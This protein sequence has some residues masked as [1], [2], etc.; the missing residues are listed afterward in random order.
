MVVTP[1]TCPHFIPHHYPSL[2]CCG[3]HLNI[4]QILAIPQIYDIPLV[5]KWNMHFACSWIYIFFLPRGERL[6]WTEEGKKSLEYDEC[7]L[8]TGVWVV[9]FCQHC[10]YSRQQSYR[11]I[12]HTIITVI[13]CRSSYN[14]SQ[15]ST[16][17]PWQHKHVLTQ[18]ALHFNVLH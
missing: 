13:S 5:Q 15:L 12:S 7:V 1:L 11:P 16:S 2:L 8:A 14:S 10:Y 9:C 6:C 18:K 4:N 17:Q 3:P